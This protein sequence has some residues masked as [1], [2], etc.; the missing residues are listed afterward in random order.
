MYI[1][2]AVEEVRRRKVKRACVIRYM[3]IL[4]D[5]MRADKSFANIFI[6]VLFGEIKHLSRYSY[7]TIIR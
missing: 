1:Q 2:T 7:N 4:I 5:N 6:F 3:H